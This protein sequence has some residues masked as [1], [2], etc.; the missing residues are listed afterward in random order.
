MRMTNGTMSWGED[1]TKPYFTAPVE[2]R[3]VQGLTLEEIAATPSPACPGNGLLVQRNC[4]GVT[5]HMK[6]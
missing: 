1:I 6:R 2:A 5:N 3:G 4:S